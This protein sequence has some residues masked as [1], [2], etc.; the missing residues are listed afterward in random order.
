[1][2]ETLHILDMSQGLHKESSAGHAEAA[3]EQQKRKQLPNII[4]Q[5]PRAAEKPQHS[6][7]QANRAA[8]PAG[9]KPCVTLSRCCHLLVFVLSLPYRKKHLKCY[10]LNLWEIAVLYLS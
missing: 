5:T 7:E 9:T 8:A 2:L 3:T 10:W 4:E 1:M 6:A